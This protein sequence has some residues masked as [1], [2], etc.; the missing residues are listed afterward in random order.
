MNFSIAAWAAWSTGLTT[1]GQWLAWAAADEG[2]RVETESESVPQLAAMPVLLR[3]RVQILGR[4]AL[5]TMYGVAERNIPII[6]C[7]RYGELHR[8]LAL[9]QELAQTNNVSPQNFCMAVHNGIPSLYTIAQKSHVPVSAVS[10]GACSA[11]YGLIEAL[12]LLAED[13]DQVRLV[14]A[15]QALPNEYQPYAD[16]QSATYAYTLDVIKGPDY[17]LEFLSKDSLNVK[18]ITNSDLRTRLEKSCMRESSG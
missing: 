15:N 18:P 17:S 12:A 7:S 13:Y 8:A 16:Q 10:A 5:E 4:M 2:R 3:R 1:Q 14:V 11:I 9:L 6:F